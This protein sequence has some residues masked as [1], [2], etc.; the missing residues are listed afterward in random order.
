MST[1]IRDIE[2]FLAHLCFNVV[3]PALSGKPLSRKMPEV[4]TPAVSQTALSLN[5]L[6]MS[7]CIVITVWFK[8]ITE[9]KSNLFISYFGEILPVLSNCFAVK[10]GFHML[11]NQISFYMSRDDHHH[12]TQT[13]REGERD[14]LRISVNK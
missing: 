6:S 4:G 10:W 3:S 5:F 1:I 9:V 11:A 13:N 12:S 8:K 7:R 2:T 14:F